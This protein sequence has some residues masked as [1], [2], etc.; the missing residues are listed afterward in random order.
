[1][2]DA[3]H[4]ARAGLA[5]CGRL[6]ALLQSALPGQ[7]PLADSPEPPLRLPAL[8][9]LPPGDLLRDPAVRSA[10]LGVLAN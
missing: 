2:A 3:T 9:R 10:Y 1:M 4:N 6:V 8:F 5:G 7:T